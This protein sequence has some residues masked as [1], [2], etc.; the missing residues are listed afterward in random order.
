MPSAFLDRESIMRALTELG[1]RLHAD[2]LQGDVFVV[3]GAAMALAYDERRFTRDVDAIFEP[4]MHIYRLAVEVADELGLPGDWLNDGVKGFVVDDPTQG[5]VFQF[6]GL[7]VQA[8]SPEL[9]LALKVRAARM[10]EDD[11]DVRLLADMLG[12]HTAAS[13]SIV[14]ARS[15]VN[16]TRRRARSSSSRRL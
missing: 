11:E 7:R 16:D 8:A 9:L 4:K 1:R 5:P 13:G 14:R 6:E 12:L 15:S 10:G 3:G 2:G